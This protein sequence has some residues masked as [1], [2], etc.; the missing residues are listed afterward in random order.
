MDVIEKEKLT[1]FL[2]RLQYNE[3]PVVFVTSGGTRVPLEKNM[4]RFIDNFSG[5]DRG[6]TSA[7]YFLAKGYAVIFMYR[8]GTKFPFSRAFGKTCSDRIDDKL[9]TK[10]VTSTDERKDAKLLLSKK[11]KFL[12][13]KEAHLLRKSFAQQQ[14]FVISFT[15]VQD[16][17]TLLEEISIM[18]NPFGPRACFYLAAAVSDFYIPID[19]V[20]NDHN[21]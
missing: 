14:L 6:A 11:G 10:I 12:V 18:L 4:V 21:P 1:S 8:V 20:N 5:G 7:E 19:K 15:T 13:T 17:L 9:L 2:E 3:Q 16:Y